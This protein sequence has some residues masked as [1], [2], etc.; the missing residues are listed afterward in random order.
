MAIIA[1]LIT[2]MYLLGGWTSIDAGEYAIVIKQF[3]ADKGIMDEGLKVGT[4]WIEPFTKDVE[5]YDTKARQ[6]PLEVDAST[7]DGQPVLVTASFEISLE[8]EKVKALHSL[9]GRNYYE[10]VVAPAATAAVRDALPTQLSDKVYTDA[11]RVFIQGSIVQAL[12][13]KNIKSRGIIAH[14]N[15]QEIK[16][17]NPAFVQVLEQKASAAQL[18]EIE[19]RKAMAAEQTAIGVVNTA[20]GEKQKKIKESEATREQLRLA[21]EGNRLRDEETA[22]G[23]LALKQAEAEGQRLLVNAYGDN[24]EIVSQIEWA[25]NVGN[26]IQIYG[27]PTGAPGTTSLID[28]QGI[29]Q[30]GFGGD[31]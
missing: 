12:E 23:Q 6:Y 8:A 7:K 1:V 9:I 15:L 4:H 11:G 18:E 28:V 26:K 13:E 19:R 24:P 25:R 31:K 22:K 29:I 21:G 2:T 17:L 27:I 3:G 30:K 14:I 10:D 5:V 20:E 16:F